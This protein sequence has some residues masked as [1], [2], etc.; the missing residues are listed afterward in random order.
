MRTRLHL[1][2]FCA[3]LVTRFTP[4]DTRLHHAMELARLRHTFTV[5]KHIKQTH[6]FIRMYLNPFN[7]MTASCTISS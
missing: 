4:K 5:N 1:V 3:A 7:T 2:L 6:K